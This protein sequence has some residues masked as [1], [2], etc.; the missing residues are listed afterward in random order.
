MEFDKYRNKKPYPIKPVKPYPQNQTPQA[1]RLLADALEQYE[2]EMEQYRKEKAEYNQETQR[3]KEVF[4]M[5][6]FL[7]CNIDPDHPKAEK[8]KELAWRYGHSSGFQ[9]VYNWFCELSELID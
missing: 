6:C 4:W 9:E 5:D 8:L 1:Y 3:I 2:R 7:D